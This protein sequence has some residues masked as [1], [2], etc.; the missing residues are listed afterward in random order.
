VALEHREPPI[1]LSALTL[2]CTQ[3]QVVGHLAIFRQPYLDKIL[4][5]EKTI[6]S[7]FSRSRSVPFEKVHRGDLILLKETAGPICAVA[8][9]EL[10]RCFGPL[11]SGEAE[12]LMAIYQT[13]LQLKD[14]FKR[15]KQNS[16]Y[17]TLITFKDVFP[18][19]PIQVKKVD[20]RA[21]V[22][23]KENK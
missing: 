22:I 17:A 15:A 19:K 8:V 20:R 21:W 4:S 2:T 10:I 1:D 7:R 14:D 5:G 3:Q 6:E 23:L 9:A 18:I 16:L 12:H 13:E 11:G